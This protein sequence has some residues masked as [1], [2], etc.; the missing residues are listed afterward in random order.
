MR[1]FAAVLFA[2]ALLAGCQSAPQSTDAV[3]TDAVTADAPQHLQELTD[4]T[5]VYT[6]PACN[7]DYDRA[8]QCPMCKVDLVETGIAYVCPADNQPVERA[9]KCPRCNMN[10]KI[11]RTAMAVDAAGEVHGDEAGAEAAPGH[12]AGDGH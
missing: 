6:C 12:E 2:I 10:A 3:A 9:G 4:Q 7:M 8:G 11:I 5:T 1:V